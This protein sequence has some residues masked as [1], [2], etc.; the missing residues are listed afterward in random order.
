[1][2]VLLQMRSLIYT[3]NSNDIKAVYKKDKLLGKLIK[4][5][6]DIEISLRDDYFLSLVRAIVG[7]QLSVKAAATI[8]DRLMALCGELSP[9]RILEL[10][11]EELRGVGLSRGKVVYIR[12]LASRVKNGDLKLDRIEELEDENIIKSLTEIKGIGKWTAEMFLIFSLGRPNIFSMGD[13]GLQRSV[14][15]LYQ[16]EE[17]SVQY[18]KECQLKWSPYGTVASIYLWEA[19]NRGYVDGYK[20]LKEAEKD[21]ALK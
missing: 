2:E 14:M 5:I 10:Q 17:V 13:L 15:W 8:N 9:D 18:L 20:S 1:M 19:I 7:Q 4:F 11:E 16:M 6:G 3:L 21:H 12:D